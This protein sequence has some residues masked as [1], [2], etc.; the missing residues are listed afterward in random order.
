MDQHEDDDSE[1]E[2]D[3]YNPEAEVEEKKSS[4]RPRDGGKTSG[5]K[6]R[7]PLMRDSTPE[8]EAE[9]GTTATGV[10]AAEEEE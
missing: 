8:A 3:D 10:T 9:A 6:G 2:D 7:N 5:K 4:K 1:S